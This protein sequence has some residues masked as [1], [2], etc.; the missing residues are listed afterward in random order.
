MTMWEWDDVDCELVS[1]AERPPP[2]QLALSILPEIPIP[3]TWEKPAI[4]RTGMPCIPLEEYDIHQDISD[5]FAFLSGSG[6]AYGYVASVYRSEGEAETYRRFELTERVAKQIR[7]DR[8]MDSAMAFVDDRMSCVIVTWWSD[9][10]LL[11]MREELF[12]AYLNA[13]PLD[14][15]RNLLPEHAA[16]FPRVDNLLDAKQWGLKRRNLFGRE[17]PT[18]FG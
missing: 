2:V 17:S 16:Q 13:H 10:A 11:G 8:A 15:G 7:Q 3:G 9:Y 6:S 14:M 12:E 5:I 1:A 18:S 4:Q